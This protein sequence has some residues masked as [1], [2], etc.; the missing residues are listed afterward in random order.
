[1]AGGDFWFKMALY[2]DNLYT[3]TGRVAAARPGAGEEQCRQWLNNAIRNVINKRLYWVEL[4]KVGIIPVPSQTIT[5]TISTVPGSKQVTG[6]ATAWPVTDVVNTTL[7]EPVSDPGYQEVQLASIAGV[8]EDSILW[9]DGGTPSAEAVPVMRINR[10]GSGPATIIGAFQFAHPTGVSVTQSSL[11]QQ[12]F[13]TG[14]N[15]PVFTVMAVT[16]PQTLMMDNAWGGLPLT[17]VAYCIFKMYYTLFPNLRKIIAAVDHQQGIPLDFQKTQQ[18]LNITDPQRTDNSDP[19][20]FVS[21]WPNANGNMQ[22]EIWPAPKSARQVSILATLQWPELVNPED[23]PPFFLEPTIF[24]NLAAAEGLRHRLR[25]DDP[26]FDPKLSQQ[27]QLE[28]QA[29]LQDALIG[30]EERA[31]MDYQ[32]ILSSMLPLIGANSQWSLQHAV[33]AVGFDF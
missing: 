31:I 20:A 6:V 24:T 10:G 17:N 28:A 33:S 4:R 2:S 7:A 29:Q 8:T 12:Q 3:M 26:F 14:F 25:K 16:D 23:L 30:D 15:N 21:A 32:S 1:M 11:V 27:F 13:R 19:L 22:W 5:G 18:E 9:V